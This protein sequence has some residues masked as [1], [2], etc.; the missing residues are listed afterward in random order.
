MQIAFE[1]YPQAKSVLFLDADML[2]LS[3]LTPILESLAGHAVLL[4][5][6][7]LE[8]DS[9]LPLQ[10]HQLNRVGVFNAGVI[11]DT[12]EHGSPVLDWYEARLERDCLFDHSRGLHLDQ[13]WL[14]LI[15]SLFEHTVIY[16]H[17]GANVAYW[18]L[19]E[20]QLERGPEGYRVGESPLLLFHFSGWS[21]RAPTRLS[22]YLGGGFSPPEDSA[23]SELLKDYS[24]QV[25]ESS[26]A[27]LL[28]EPSAYDFYHSG[29]KIS[30]LDSMIY[31]ALIEEQLPDDYDPYGGLPID[32]RVRTLRLFEYLM[33][34][35]PWSHD[36]MRHL[37]GF[38]TL[39][40]LMRR[41]D[42]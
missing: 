12:R 31:E 22:H 37:P 19:C 21:E 30:D 35:V 17:A 2:V 40:K 29:E 6:H 13:K 26:Y 16:R 25:M 3:P 14:D 7:L 24:Q 34:G 23:L 8:P 41:R 42:R 38:K 28:G 18:N 11:G 5:P 4:T 9:N 15:P 1:R 39:V 32:W 20:R 33:R 27:D 10:E 36:S